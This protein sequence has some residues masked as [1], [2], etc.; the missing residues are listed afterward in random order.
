MTAWISYV[1]LYFLDSRDTARSMPCST[2]SV[3]VILIPRSRSLCTNARNA[4]VRAFVNLYVRVDVFGFS[5][6]RKFVLLVCFVV[7]IDVVE[8]DVVDV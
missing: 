3:S 7:E 4:L 2:I 6:V 1:T 5:V 8:I